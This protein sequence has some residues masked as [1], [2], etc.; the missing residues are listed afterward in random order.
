M[1]E[2]RPMKKRRLFVPL[3]A[4]TILVSA[5]LA[6]GQAA[7][8]LIIEITA[9]PNHHLLFENQ[10]VRVFKIDL[11]PHA[12]MLLHHHRHDY[13]FVVLGASSIENDIVGQAPFLRKF[14]EGESVFVPGPF[15][16]T[17]TN[18]SDKP[19]QV[20]AVEI[21]KTDPAQLSHE[22]DED[23][24]LH[25]LNGGTLDILF[26]KDGVRA[27]DL[28]LNPGGIVPKHHHDGPHVVIAITDLNLRSDIEGKGAI[29]VQLKA[30][31][32][33]WAKGDVTHTVTNAGSQN[34][35]LITLEFP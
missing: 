1:L 2:S 28:Q 9:E 4:S 29:N 13:I 30:G 5:T 6:A 34:A 22:W 21:M 17:A 20:I 33:A 35:R 11:A 19:F 12:A 32:A 31:E 7:A 15:A 3:L 24:G 26:V 27:A 14:Q 10:Y 16:H 18:L 8:P 23:R 25:I